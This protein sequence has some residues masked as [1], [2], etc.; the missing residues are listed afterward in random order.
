M[1]ENAA[2]VVAASTAEGA[3]AL[4]PALRRSVASSLGSFRRAVCCFG[5]GTPAAGAAGAD[6]GS[7]RTAGCAAYFGRSSF[8]GGGE[9]T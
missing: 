9:R 2:P 7:A 3:F 8:F 5:P 6:G 4:A 1:R